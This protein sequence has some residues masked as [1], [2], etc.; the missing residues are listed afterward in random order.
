MSLTGRVEDW[1]LSLSNVARQTEGHASPQ[2]GCGLFTQV[3][4][5]Y[6]GSQGL[7]EEASC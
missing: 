6:H 2:G 3:F 1:I 5:F 7:T 4:F